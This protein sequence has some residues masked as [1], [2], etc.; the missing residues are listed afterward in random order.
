MAKLLPEELYRSLQ[1]CQ[2]DPSLDTKA[3]GKECILIRDGMSGETLIEPH[4]PGVRRMQMQKT[5]KA[6]AKDLN[7]IYGKKL[8]GITITNEK[9]SLVTAHFAD[10]TSQS[11]SVLVGADGGASQ[12]R[13]WLLGDLAE[14]EVLPYQFMNFSFTL[15]AEKALHLD[16]VM[17]PNVDV[18][19]HPKG[20]YLGLFLLDKPDVSKPEGWV[21]YLLVTWP[22]A[23]K[24]DEEN[25]D[26]RLE[27]LR[28][29]ME[30]WADPY[31]SVVEWLPDDVVIKADQLRI[32]SPKPWNNHGG[33]IT[34]A[35]D[36]AH[37]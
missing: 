27:R 18:A 23:T 1:S 35:G 19:P 28:A 14:P 24:E 11:G 13:R 12:V 16:S 21:F 31:K 32:W 22:I 33:R 6:W 5:K 17:N 29:H 3:A 15:P 9:P 2:P 10:G 30:G 20:M 4:F 7:I 34:L 37:R 36:A 26:N 8:S 25:S